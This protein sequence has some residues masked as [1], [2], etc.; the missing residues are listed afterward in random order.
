MEPVAAVTGVKPELPAPL[1]EQAAAELVVIWAPVAMVEMLDKQ[2][3][4][5]LLE[6]AE[7]EVEEA[8]ATVMETMAAAVVVLVY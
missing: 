5:P 4:T 7:V 6:A 2:G 3:R 1:R 8:R